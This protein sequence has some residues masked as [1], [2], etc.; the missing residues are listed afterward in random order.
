MIFLSLYSRKL[1]CFCCRES[2]TLLT[3]RTARALSLV[4]YGLYHLV[5][6]TLPCRLMSS[7]KWIIAGSCERRLRDRAQRAA[8][9]L[10]ARRKGGVVSVRR[11]GRA[12]ATGSALTLLP[13][14]LSVGAGAPPVSEHGVVGE[15]RCW[16]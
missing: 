11:G 9:S 10:P 8:P 7:T 12:T 13:P 15:A 3:S 4:E 6:R 2:T 1:H 5:S 16:R 14:R